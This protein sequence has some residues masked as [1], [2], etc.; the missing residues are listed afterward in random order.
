MTVSKK[1]LPSRNPSGLFPGCGRHPHRNRLHAQG[2]D[3]RLL[4]PGR[5]VELEGCPRRCPRPDER[6]A[7]GP[8]VQVQEGKK[9]LEIKPAGTKKGDAVEAFM[10]E[11]PF[12]GCWPAWGHTLPHW[13]STGFSTSKSDRTSGEKP[14]RRADPAP[15]SYATPIRATV[16]LIA[17]NH[18]GNAGCW[19][20]VYGRDRGRTW[21]AAKTSMAQKER[22]A[23]TRF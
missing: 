14:L 3:R 8:T 4:G 2:R 18:P 17:R 15:Q 20:L 22:E 12:A 21:H 5:P 6:A 7:T 13:P 9:V 19:R 23:A 16:R 11:C 1:N 10:A